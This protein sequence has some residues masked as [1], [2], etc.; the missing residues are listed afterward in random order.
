VKVGE[1]RD[2][3]FA[4]EGEWMIT[5]DSPEALERNLN[6]EVIYKSY[7]MTTDEL[8]IYMSFIDSETNKE[9]FL[10]IV[11]GGYS[12]LLLDHFGIDFPETL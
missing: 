3:A 4:D 12:F 9:E 2:F 8:E 6:A 7:S 1:V 10:G 5:P 11:S